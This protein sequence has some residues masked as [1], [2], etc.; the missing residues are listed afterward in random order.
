MHKKEWTVNG[1]I[2]DF[3]VASVYY[4]DPAEHEE[5][6]IVLD[7]IKSRQVLM[8]MGARASGKTTRLFRLKSQLTED[9]YH[10]YM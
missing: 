6:Q 5:N 8:L 3:N 1:A 10:C 7:S 9:G 2:K 4:V